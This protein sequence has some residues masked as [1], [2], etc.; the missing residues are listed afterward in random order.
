MEKKNHKQFWE[1]FTCF[2]QTIMLQMQRIL[3]SHYI[4][5]CLAAATIYMEHLNN[6]TS[7]AIKHSSRLEIKVIVHYNTATPNSTNFASKLFYYVFFNL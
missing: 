6:E 3:T 2:K 7:M 1:A 5:S 4:V